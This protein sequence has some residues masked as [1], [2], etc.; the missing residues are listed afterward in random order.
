[1]PHDK[2]ELRLNRHGIA[3]IATL[4]F[5][6]TINSFMATTPLAAGST[7]DLSGPDPEA[8]SQQ[9]LEESPSLVSEEMEAE[10]DAF[11]CGRCRQRKTRYFQRQT[12]SADEPMTIFVT[13]TNCGN[14]WKFS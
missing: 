9:A 6:P 5:S 12:R 4:S 11:Q 13:C 2:Y 3:A 8:P 14:K 1:M 10:T 7:Q